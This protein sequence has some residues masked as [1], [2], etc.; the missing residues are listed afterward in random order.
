MNVVNDMLSVWNI[1]DTQLLP[2][3]D[4]NQQNQLDYN[5]V[6]VVCMVGDIPVYSLVV[7]DKRYHY[8]CLPSNVPTDTDLS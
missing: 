4:E 6:C 2:A 3:Y 1:G 5:E 8:K 7:F